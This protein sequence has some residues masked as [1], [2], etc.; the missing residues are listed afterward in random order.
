MAL[1][2]SMTMRERKQIRLS[3][4]DYSTPGAYFVTICVHNRDCVLGRITDGKMDLNQFGKIVLDCWNDLPNHYCNCRLGE[5]VVMPDHV[6]GI[7][8]IVGNGLKPF[9]TIANGTS[10]VPDGSKPSAEKWHGLPEIMRG[11]KTF[12]SRRINES[13]PGD[14]FQWQKSYHDHIIRN[15]DELWR[16]GRYIRQN[17]QKWPHGAAGIEK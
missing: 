1:G 15:E 5:F 12:S 11:L 8:C 2:V 13:H 10:V 6:H 14:R 17:P 7:V 4:F 3:G 16:I 9:P